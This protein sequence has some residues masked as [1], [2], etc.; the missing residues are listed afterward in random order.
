MCQGHLR[1]CLRV[2]GG[3]THPQVPA[4]TALA[5]LTSFTGLAALSSLATLTYLATL[6]T[7]AAIT[8]LNGLASLATLAVLAALWAF[9]TALVAL[10]VLATSATSAECPIGSK[11]E[12]W[13]SKAGIHQLKLGLVRAASRPGNPANPV[14]TACPSYSCQWVCSSVTPLPV[15]RSP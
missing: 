3:P 14:A 8:A 5:S 9:T 2:R 1:R 13:E 6:S 15:S 7:L 10:T 12:A 4:A 11:G